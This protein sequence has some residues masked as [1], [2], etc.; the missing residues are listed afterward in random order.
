LNSHIDTNTTSD[1]TYSALLAVGSTQEIIINDPKNGIEQLQNFLNEHK[2]WTF[3]YLSYD[4]KE[5]TENILSKNPDFIKFPLIHFFVP[6]LVIEIYNNNHVLHFDENILSSDKANAIYHLA[7]SPANLAPITP[8]APKIQN[9]ISKQEYC[10]AF[11]HLKNH[12][13]RGDIYEVNF[14]Q[15]FFAEN[16]MIDPVHTF[17]KLDSISNAPFAAFC[18]FDGNFIL[19]SSPERFIKREGSKL[20]SQ[21]IKGTIKR[22]ANKKEDEILKNIL[23]NDL[24]EQTEN[25]MIV[26]L[27]RNDLSKVAKKGSVC[28]D[29]LFGVHTFQQVHHLIST[30]SCEIKQKEN[31]SDILKATFPMGSMTGAPKVSALNLIEK[32]ETVKRGPYSGAIGYIKPDGDFDF[33]VIIRA[34]F[35]NSKEHYLSFSTGSAITSAAEADKEYDEC[36]LKAKAMFNV[37]K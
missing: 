7:F 17:E 21:P 20:Y 10:E 32:Y 6:E 13:A 31:F 11:N 12:I 35:Y 22:S 1:Y 2:D 33:S 34:I 18:K 8:P 26:D 36:L 37:L 27:V 16:A 4:M 3:G 29:E 25:V 14:C 19:S 23:R 5:E 24:K 28:V 30:V 15:E 9:R